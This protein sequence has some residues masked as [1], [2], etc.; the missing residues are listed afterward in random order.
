[1]HPFARLIFCL[2]AVAALPL[3]S[4]AQGLRSDY[5][6]AANLGDQLTRLYEKNAVSYRWAGDGKYLAF[7]APRSPQP[8]RW[9]VL[10][11]SGGKT[12]WVAEDQLVARLGPPPAAK[13]VSPESLPGRSNHMGTAVNLT[14]VNRT[15]GEIELIWFDP[16][17]NRKSYGKLAPGESRAQPTYEKHVWIVAD[18][19]GTA[20][21]G[22][23]APGEDSLV[24]I[25]GRVAPSQPQPE[26]RS[27]DG[28]WEAFFR[29]HNLYLKKLADGTETA[30]TTDGKPGFAYEPPVLW[31]PDSQ[32]LA[33]FHNKRPETRVVT[34]VQSSP[35]DQLQ[36]KIIRVPYPKPGDPIPVIRPVLF[37]VANHSAV[38]IDESRMPN[39]WDIDHA[40]WSGDSRELLFLYNQ[41]GHQV[42]RYLAAD[43]KTGKTR[44]VIEETSKTFIDYSSKTF[45]RR[46]PKTGE[47]LWASE[48]D[49]WNHLYLIREKDGTLKNRVTTGKWNVKEVMSVDEDKR[50]IVF[51]AVGIHPEQDPYYVHWCRVNFDGTGLV[52]LTSGDGTH[53]VRF[54]PDGSH[55]VDHWSRV[56]QP[57][58]T[59]VRRGRDGSLV[60]RIQEADDS[61]LRKT[62]WSRPERFHAAGRDGKTEIYGILVK[63]SN[64][65]PAVKYP[66]IEGIYAG[67]QDSFVPKSY[68][69]WMSM[70]MNALAEL[71]FIVVQIDGMGTNWRGK[72]FH[73]ICWKNLADS[74]LPDRIAWI[75]AAAATR[76]WMDISRV[77]IYGGSAGGQSALS[78]LLHHGEFYKAGLAD[79]GC[80][81]N[82]IDK[83]WWNEAWMGWP[84]DD[85]YAKNSNV[86]DARMLTGKLML[87][88]GELD[89]NVDPSSTLQVA[90]ALEKADKDFELV[91]VTGS[92]HGSAESPYGKRRRMDFFVRNLLGRE[93]RGAK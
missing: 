60:M 52:A 31:S 16:A 47:I 2:L 39:P 7:H 65:N 20:L 40:E 26:G 17:G 19:S 12:E 44:T 43:A 22:I 90:N 42:M 41:R 82:R 55:F 4:R 74:G 83:I 14:F 73:D 75:K 35:P 8:T 13:P 68:S 1:M 93:P 62:G 24:P 80:H 57:Q 89:T 38:P 54:S 37:R 28:K 63:P 34:L 79:C 33:A 86:T 77:G 21:A 71:G 5:E 59:E 32:G 67:P 30:F 72:A 9:G 81:D 85:S 61:E 49:G 78:A 25:T 11:L 29:N 48:R 46:L 64:F 3:P 56:D 45:L 50:T 87:M 58:V 53:E 91:I 23:Q 70:D 66:V 69:P 92:D 84:V 10:D 6:R 15:K 18:A 51:R 27:P 36:P 88:V 76:P